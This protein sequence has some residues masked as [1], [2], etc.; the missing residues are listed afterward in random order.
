MFEDRTIDIQISPSQGMTAVVDRVVFEDTFGPYQRHV[1]KI[2][3]EGFDP[4]IILPEDPGVVP[5]LFIIQLQ[6]LLI[7]RLS[8]GA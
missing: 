5:Y 6:E 2:R 4:G 7:E 8:V 3:R 1:Y